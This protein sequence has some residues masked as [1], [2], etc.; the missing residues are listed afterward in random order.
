MTPDDLGS[1][2][3]KI[4]AD[5]KHRVVIFSSMPRRPSSRAWRLFL[6]LILAGVALMLSA[7]LVSYVRHRTLEQRLDDW[8]PLLTQEAAANGLDVRLVRAVVRAE[9]GGRAEA[10][11]AKGARGL[12]QL[13]DAAVAD[14][15]RR[16]DLPAGEVMD[17]AYNVMIGARYLRHLLDRF[18]G[19]VALAVAAYHMGPT[20]VSQ[21]ARGQPEMDS[22]ALIAKHAG[23]ATKAYVKNVLGYL[24]KQP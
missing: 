20:R 19:D 4:I 3:P 18:D 11:S 6:A 22:A 14:M 13:T 9:S 12:M 15:C 5:V 17:P 7:P 2:T 8:M 23:P 1:V 21:H 10:V 24:E 16:F